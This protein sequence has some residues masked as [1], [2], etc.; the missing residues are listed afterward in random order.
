MIEALSGVSTGAASTTFGGSPGNAVPAA[1]ALLGADAAA[2]L[3]AVAGAVTAVPT[4]ALG[5]T[6]DGAIAGI[7]AGVFGKDAFGDAFAMAEGAAEGGAAG[8][9]AI[10]G[11]APWLCGTARDDVR[12]ALFGLSFGAAAATE[13]GDDGLAVAGDGLVAGAAVVGGATGAIDGTAAV[14]TLVTIARAAVGVF[15]GSAER[16]IKESTTPA[17]AVAPIA[18]ATRTTRAVRAKLGAGAK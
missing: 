18:V 14:R 1:D 17:P 11:A 6:A 16:S 4:S 7:D 12:A 9:F 8:L 5:L 2:G 15:S 10:A 13:A 3:A